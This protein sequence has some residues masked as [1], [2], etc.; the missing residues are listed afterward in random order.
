MSFFL[1]VPTG[2]LHELLLA[3][4]PEFFSPRTMVNIMEIPSEKALIGRVS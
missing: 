2:K 4:L 1:T 3:K